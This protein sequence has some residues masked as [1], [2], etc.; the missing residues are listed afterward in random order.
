VSFQGVSFACLPA[1]SAS[2]WPDALPAIPLGEE[3][4]FWEARPALLRF[5]FAGVPGAVSH[6][7][8]GPALS[9]QA[10]LLVYPGEA[11]RAIDR[12]IRLEFGELVELLEERPVSID[13]EMPLLPLNNLNQVLHARVHYLDFATGSGV[14]YLT[15]L[16]M[17]PSPINNQE[18]FYTIQA[19]TSDRAYYVAAFFPVTLP[20]LPPTAQLSDEEFVNLM[21]NYQA[22]LADTITLLEAQPSGAFTPDLAQIDRLIESLVLN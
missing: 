22:Y 1:L 3:V 6:A 19:L 16:A 9:N 5:T 4:P 13:G 18:L 21:T 15:Q 8:L 2:L 12:S 10:Q 20:G 14:G 11:L 17:G 7:H